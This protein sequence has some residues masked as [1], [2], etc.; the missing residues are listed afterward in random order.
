MIG[1]GG[2]GGHR[3]SDYHVQKKGCLPHQTC[4]AFLVLVFALLGVQYGSFETLWFQ[5]SRLQTQNHLKTRLPDL[6]QMLSRFQ[7]RAKIF[8]DPH[9]WETILYPLFWR[10]WE[11]QCLFC[12]LHNYENT[13]NYKWK[14]MK[15]IQSKIE[16]FSTSC[17]SPSIC[18]EYCLRSTP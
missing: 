10:S 18:L 4:F 2:G 7:D 14:L 15:R 16:A 1:G 8:W 17:N 12:R 13:P 5:N 6:S 9:F 3:V 11:K